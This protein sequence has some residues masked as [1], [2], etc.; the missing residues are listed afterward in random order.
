MRQL[1]S[2]QGHWTVLQAFNAHLLC[3]FFC[4]WHVGTLNSAQ[5]TRTPS[6]SGPSQEE[7]LGRGASA[8]RQFHHSAAPVCTVHAVCTYSMNADSS[9]GF[10]CMNSSLLFVIAKNICSLFSARFQLFLCVYARTCTC[11]YMCS[12]VSIA[13]AQLAMVVAWRTQ[14]R[15]CSLVKR[16]RTLEVCPCIFIQLPPQPLVTLGKLHAPTLRSLR[17]GRACPPPQRTLTPFSSA[18]PPLQL[19]L[20]ALPL[21]P[22]TQHLNQIHQDSLPLLQCSRRM[23]R[24]PLP[25]RRRPPLLPPPRSR[26]SSLQ[27]RPAQSVRLPPTT[28]SPAWRITRHVCAWVCVHGRVCMGCVGHAALLVKVHHC[29]LSRSGHVGVCALRAVW[30]LMRRLTLRN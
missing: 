28:L 14:T 9:P 20:K 19:H 18:P 29:L 8:S 6:A 30:T 17:V 7:E 21:L 22:R 11:E 2:S 26:Q 1:R 25:L 16:V 5:Q 23:L 3:S 4:A 24:R 13:C 27:P 10:L 12:Y 15:Y